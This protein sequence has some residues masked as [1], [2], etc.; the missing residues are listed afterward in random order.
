MSS[1]EEYTERKSNDSQTCV[2][3]TVRPDFLKHS[4]C[5]SGHSCLIF[6][7]VDS[8]ENLWEQSVSQTVTYTHG[9]WEHSYYRIEQEYFLLLHTL[10]LLGHLI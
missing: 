2:E 1:Q 5:I 9:H 10:W 3:L 6:I 4:I 8:V 7:W